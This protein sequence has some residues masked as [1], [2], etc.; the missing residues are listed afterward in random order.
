MIELLRRLK[1]MGRQGA[2]LNMSIRHLYFVE[3]HRNGKLLW[4]DNFHN[5]TTTEGVTKYLDA[6]LKTGLTTPAWYVLLVKAKGGSYAIGDTIA[7]H[8]GWTEAVSGG[9][10][11]SGNRPAWTPGSFTGTS[12]VSIDNSASKASFTMAGT[13]TIYGAGMCSAA[14]GTSGTLL[15]VGD[16][17]GG[18]RAVQANDVLSV[19]VTCQ[20]ATA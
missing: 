6:T 16:F 9:T 11:Y 12:T 5:Q 1:G 3:C 8:A 20:L 2:H 19:T 18:S 7:S 14:T 17:S 4:T 10:D 15:G 13:L